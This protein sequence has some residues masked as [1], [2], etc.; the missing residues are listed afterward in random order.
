MMLDMTMYPNHPAIEAQRKETRASAQ[1]GCLGA[2]AR[3]PNRGGCLSLRESNGG[4]APPCFLG[5]KETNHLI[6]LK[7]GVSHKVESSPY[8][9]GIITTQGT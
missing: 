6:S 2:C 3:S 1:S 8:T 7:V 4:G 5:N 9:N